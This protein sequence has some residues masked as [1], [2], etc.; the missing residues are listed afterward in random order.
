M[1]VVVV[2]V[3]VV[4]MTEDDVGDYCCVALPISIDWHDFVAVGSLDGFTF[5]QCASNLPTWSCLKDH[6]SGIAM[7]CMSW[8]VS[9]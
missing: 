4:V 5:C 8:F 7:A 6:A 3:V 2:I 1:A 9:V